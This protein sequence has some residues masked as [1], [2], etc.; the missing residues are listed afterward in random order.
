MKTYTYWNN[1]KKAHGEKLANIEA[2][3]II[4]ADALFKELTGINPML[5]YI[6]VEILK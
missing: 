1:Q 4:Q 2:S 6:S 5:N 3:D